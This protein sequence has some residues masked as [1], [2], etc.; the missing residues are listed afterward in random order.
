MVEEDPTTGAKHSRSLEEAIVDTV[1]E[2]LIVLDDEMR[3]LIASRS[4][5]TAF[6][7]A[8]QET[9]GRSLFELGNGQWNIT[10]LRERLGKI[11]PEHAKIEGFEVEKYSP[12]ATT[13]RAC[14]WRLRMSPSGVRLNARRTN[15]CGRRIFSFRR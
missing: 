3:V 10:S 8:K 4:F 1:R 15:C 7:G 5:Y 12:R 9:E 14:W 2:P 13:A 11:I 6:E